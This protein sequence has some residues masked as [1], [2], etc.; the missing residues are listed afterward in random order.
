MKTPPLA[1][2]LRPQSLSEVVGQDHLLGEHGLIATTVKANKP[3]SIVLWGPP[4]CGKTSIARLYAQAFNLRFVSMSAIFSGVADLKKIVKEAQDHPLLSRGTMLF[5]DEIHRF[6]KAQQDAF[7]P[8]VE[9]GTL[10]LIGATA[11][12]PSFYLNGALLSRLRVLPLYPLDAS[13]LEVL[14]QRYE[15]KSGPL[16]LT[17]QAREMIAL[18][19]QGDGRY[20]YNLIENIRHIS[21]ETL[22]VERLKQILQKRSPLFDRAG[23]QH[24]NLISALHKSVRGSDPDAALYWLSRMLEGG[25]E[26][27][28]LARR[29]IRMAVEDIGLS[30]PHALP[31]AMAARDAYEMLG[32][33]EGELA[34]AE[35]V[36]YLALAPK[37]N[38]LYTALGKAREDAAKTTQ[39][40]PP[41]HILNAPTKLMKN[42]GYGKGY[43][44][45]HEEEEGFS[46]QNYFPKEFG[47]HSYYHPVERGFERELKKRLD[48]F[49]NKRNKIALPHDNKTG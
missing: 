33:P 48:Y 6:N 27:L 19:S 38:A 43:R 29:I 4:G 39:Y 11:E 30:D 46:G 24:Y 22:D 37:S 26:P 12:N 1:E 16:P 10:I 14:V 9:N 15:K 18:W 13:S 2:E 36:V 3:L 23:D 32:S 42:L 7:L 25:E 5:V 40:S 47:R 45:D 20:L 21:N 8:F 35:A 31:L 28:F 49:K 44:Y 34:L 41:E 17:P